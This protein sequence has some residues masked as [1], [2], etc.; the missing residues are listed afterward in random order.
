MDCTFQF[1]HIEQFVLVGNTDEHLS[2]KSLILAYLY[3]DQL[4]YPVIHNFQALWG[5]Q[6]EDPRSS[7][8]WG[9]SWTS[10]IRHHQTGLEERAMSISEQKLEH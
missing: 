6:I 7:L 5:F 4:E 10:Q 1:L 3:R 2:C 9:Q 8:H